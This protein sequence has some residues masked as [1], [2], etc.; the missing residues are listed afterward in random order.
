MSTFDEYSAR[1][2][3]FKVNKTARL[4]GQQLT[5]NFK[6]H[7]YDVSLEHWRILLFLWKEDGQSQT[8]LATSTQKDE[9]SVSRILNTMEK[10]DLVVR[11]RHPEDRRTNLIYL[12]ERGKNLRDGLMAMGS[13]TNNEA[14]D[15]INPEELVKCMKT[16]DKI[17]GN[18][19]SV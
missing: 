17:A 5:H 1:S 9:P 10:H 15:G 7:N 8:S 11:K 12:T 16:L 13:L 3:G 6:S 4:I 14:T 2:L 19:M 18:L